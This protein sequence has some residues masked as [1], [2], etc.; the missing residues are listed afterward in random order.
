MKI[1]VLVFAF[2]RSCSVCKL[3]WS[4]A[5]CAKRDTASVLRWEQAFSLWMLCCQKSA[6]FR[7]TS[8]C[9]N[10]YLCCGQQWLWC[11]QEIRLFHCARR[12]RSSYWLR[13]FGSSRRDRE[14][15]QRDKFRLVSSY[16]SIWPQRLCSRNVFAKYPKPSHAYDQ[17]RSSSTRGLD[18]HARWPGNWLSAP[19]SSLC[20][21]W[22][23]TAVAQNF[24]ATAQRPLQVCT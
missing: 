11:C 17:Q 3:C 24:R 19:C 14:S 13:S 7:K 22:R 10:P 23:E 12:L 5:V 8:D 15:D 1:G 2:Y 21:P 16:E 18:K 9:A 20:G 6:K 4:S